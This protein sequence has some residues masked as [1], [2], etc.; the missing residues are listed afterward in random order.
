MSAAV[1]YEAAHA[2][3][4]DA[5]RADLADKERADAEARSRAALAR[6]ARIGA[7]HGMSDKELRRLRDDHE[8]A[9][10]RAAITA[11]DVAAARIAVMN[12]EHDYPHA[13][14]ADE[15]ATAAGLVA[16][17]RDH[18]RRARKLRIEAD[19]IDAVEIAPL[20]NRYVDA[21]KLLGQTIDH[22]VEAPPDQPRDLADLY[23][24]T[25]RLDG[26]IVP[27]AWE[28]T[29]LGA[30]NAHMDRVHQAYVDADLARPPPELASF[31]EE[32][33]EQLAHVI[34]VRGEATASE[35]QLTVA[36]MLGQLRELAGLPPTLAD[37]VIVRVAI[38][39]ALETELVK[40]LPRALQI[41]AAAGSPFTPNGTKSDWNPGP[42][43]RPP[44]ESPAFV[45]GDVA[46]PGT[47]RG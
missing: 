9:E 25:A 27:T 5:G 34:N 18:V 37:R 42:A 30:L 33:R 24:S 8:I 12:L 31:K 1:S 4:L 23:D 38:T 44:S 2:E 46:T 16:E 40:G 28:R 11:R 20:W 10:E 17:M 19:R 6:A 32:H 22:R 21:A 41:C 15:H 36:P 26:E 43:P 45:W 39:P 3:R 29:P 35:L 7:S 47:N 14:A 13:V